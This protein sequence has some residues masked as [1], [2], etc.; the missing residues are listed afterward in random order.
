MKPKTHSLVSRWL[1]TL[2]WIGARRVCPKCEQGAMFRDHFHIHARCPH[3]NVKFQ[4][5]DGDILGV[6][7]TCYFLTLIPALLVSVAAF[8][9][10]SLST[11]QVIL[12]FCGLTALILL[13][14]FPRMKGIWVAFVYLLTGLRPNRYG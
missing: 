2:F 14:F 13:T 9:W 3:C 11:T 10:T 1:R 12:L 6:I 7:A 8:A 5:Y 4:P